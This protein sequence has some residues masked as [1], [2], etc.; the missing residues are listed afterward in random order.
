MDGAPAVDGV[1]K[2]GQVF[3][4]MSKAIWGVWIFVAISALGLVIFFGFSPR[5]I[6]KVKPSHFETPVEAFQ[7]VGHRLGQEI[8]GM[9]VVIVASPKND[10]GDSVALG[11][12]EQFGVLGFAPID[13]RDQDEMRKRIDE[14]L[15]DGSAKRLFLFVDSD[16]QPFS[17]DSPLEYLESRGKTVML[18]HVVQAPKTYEGLAPYLGKC[19]AQDRDVP[20]KRL[21]CI[22]ETEMKALIKRAQKKKFPMD[23]HWMSLSQASKSTYLLFLSER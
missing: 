19:Q 5:L 11:A 17:G 6:K 16:V 4:S 23:R 13:L 1:R 7:A 9:D 2:F 22:S 10:F 20:A 15:V 21:S 14:S 8:K 12:K 3:G 18:F